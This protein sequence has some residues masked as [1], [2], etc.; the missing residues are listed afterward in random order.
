MLKFK[1]A[2]GNIVGHQSDND[3]EPTMISMTDK[4]K[5]KKS[6]KTK[7]QMGVYEKPLIEQQDPNYIA[8]GVGPNGNGGK[9]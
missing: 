9:Q 1:D 7:K 8:S 3:S 6:N 2:N 5:S 4:K